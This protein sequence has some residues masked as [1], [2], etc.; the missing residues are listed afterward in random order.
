MLGLCCTEDCFGEL[1][2][3]LNEGRKTPQSR[4]SPGSRNG[5]ESRLSPASS[6]GSAS[7]YN[8]SGHA[9]SPRVM[10]DL[11]KTSS[12]A[13]VVELLKHLDARSLLHLA[14]EQVRSD[15]INLDHVMQAFYSHFI[16]SPLIS[17]NL[18]RAHLL[19]FHLIQA[20][21]QERYMSATDPEP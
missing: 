2:S 17:S 20:R 21:V 19:S 16:S 9:K 13:E 10:E 7:P 11:L 5:A 8:G 18:L 6:K 14:L 1:V 3:I 15:Q 12:Q 4:L